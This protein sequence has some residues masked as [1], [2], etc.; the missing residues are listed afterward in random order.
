MASNF[1]HSLWN[2]GFVEACNE[3]RRE[4]SE[5]LEK[6]ANARKANIMKKIEGV[7]KQHEKYGHESTHLFAQ[8]REEGFST[9]LQNKKLSIIDLGMSKDLQK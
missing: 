8:F 9:Y 1:A 5:K 3:K 6:N 2:P 7:K 4:A